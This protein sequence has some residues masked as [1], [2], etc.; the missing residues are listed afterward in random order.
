[1]KR[2]LPIFKIVPLQS[3]FTE[4]AIVDEPA[5]EEYFLAFSKEIKMEFDEDKMVIT[6]P[7]MIPGR[8]I[9]RNDSL[10]ER[11][12][13]YDEEGIVAAVNLFF[14]NGAQFN[15]QHTPEH[16]KIDILESYF[17]K[18]GNEFEV[19]KGSWIVTAK[20]NDANVWNDIKIGKFQGFSYQ[21]IFANELIGTEELNFKKEEDYMDLKEKLEKLT[22]AINGILFA[23]DPVVD[24]ATSGTEPATPA[25]DP[26]VAPDE[27]Q[28]KIDEAVMAAKEEI[29][30]AVAGQLE[31]LKAEVETLAAQVQA[32][33]SAL[34]AFGK[35][36]LPL[37]TKKEE[38]INLPA[39][40]NKAV[41]YF[42]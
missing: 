21:A 16:A 39:S 40:T 36:E 14:K 30:A 22:E 1:M 35:Q 29:L 19:P 24:P 26:A 25:V 23:T 15:K 32:N 9:Y 6:G 42:S 7:V 27:V 11:F 4:I 17:A 10:G 34:Q 18:D 33:D 8:L 3:E 5:I 41:A 28:S 13:T 12:V 2:T 38:V 37:E 31:A 20:V